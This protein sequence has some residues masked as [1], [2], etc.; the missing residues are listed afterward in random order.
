MLANIH[1]PNVIAREQ[2]KVLSAIYFAETIEMLR[3]PKTQEEID[4]DNAVV[5]LEDYLENK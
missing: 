5:E 1:D 2:E 4:Y 3:K